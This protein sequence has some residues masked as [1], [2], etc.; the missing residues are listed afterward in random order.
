MDVE[1]INIFIESTYHVLETMAS[2]KA[3]VGKPFLK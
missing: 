1:I 3:Q 2:T